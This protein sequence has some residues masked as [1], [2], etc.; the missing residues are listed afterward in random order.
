MRGMIGIVLC[1]WAALAGAQA[2]IPDQLVIDGRAEA[3]ASTPLQ[4]AL[5]S[6]EGLRERLK[7]HLPKKPCAAATRGYV[8]TWETRNDDLLL[9]KLNV[10]PCGDGKTV[11]LSL[12]FPGSSGMV[13][14][15]WYSG[16]LKMQAGGANRTL[17][18]TAG[19]VTGAASV[20]KAK[21]K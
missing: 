5:E 10:D 14:A 20:E 21:K 11:P 9:V 6:D 17:Y 2:Q 13:K 3:L 19:T 12:L 4:P 7:R 1:A 15:A 8:A 18:V 16:E